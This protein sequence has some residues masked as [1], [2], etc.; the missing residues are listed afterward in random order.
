MNENRALTISWL[1]ETKPIITLLSQNIYQQNSG[2]DF[3][4]CFFFLLF[5][6]LVM[7][8]SSFPS[9][10]TTPSPFP[11]PFSSPFPSP[12]PSPSPFSSPYPSPAPTPNCDLDDTNQNLAFGFIAALIAVLFFG[13]N[14]IPVKRFLFCFFFFLSFSFSFFLFS[15]FILLFSF[16]FSPS[17]NSFDQI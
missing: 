8:D 15:F 14:Y 9:A 11:S 4:S 3:S 7:V 16:L 5:F 12:F 6:G 10:P 17:N 2:V 13:T 1:K